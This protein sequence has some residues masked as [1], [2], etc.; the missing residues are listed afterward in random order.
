MSALEFGP[1]RFFQPRLYSIVRDGAPV[2]EI[3]C[4]RM[5][6]RATITIGN[7]TYSAAR[8][9]KMSGAFYLEANGTRLASAE[10]LSAWRGGFTVRAGAATYTLRPASVFGRTFI[11]AENEADI[12][13]IARQSFFGSK[14][15]AE[16][17]DNLALEI[18]AF[19]I[20]LVITV[21]Q[22]AMVAGV[23]A[24]TAGR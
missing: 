7:A 3:D 22:Q 14:S 24:G 11:L 2:G 15:R 23:V 12:G 4:D 9:G 6:Q 20:W 8:Q 16:L 17:P 10:R 5:W 18:K 21:R 13:S 1:K 19:L